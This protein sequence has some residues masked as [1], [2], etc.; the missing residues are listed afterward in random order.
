[1]PDLCISTYFAI[2]KISPTICPQGNTRVIDL[3]N[4]REV[5]AVLHLATYPQNERL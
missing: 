4:A 5:A 3:G 1:M 2:F